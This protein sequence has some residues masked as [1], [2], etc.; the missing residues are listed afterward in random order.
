MNTTKTARLALGSLATAAVLGGG[1]AALSA[2]Q[3]DPMP[4]N[5]TVAMANTSTVQVATADAELT[6][7]LQFAIEEEQMARDLY[8]VLADQY[9]GAAPFVN[10]TRS[11][12]KHY[13]SVSTLL[14]RYGVEDLG[15]DLPVGSFAN[16]DVQKLYDDWLAQ[17][18]TSLEDAYD[19]GI[20]LEKRDIADLEDALASD[21]PA[22]VEQV[23]SMLLNAS[24]HHL[25]AYES[26][27]AGTLGT[28]TGPMGRQGDAQRA[29]SGRGP[30]SGGPGAGGQAGGMGMHS[31][32]GNGHGNGGGMGLH[33][34]SGDCPMDTA[35]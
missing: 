35:S 21:L 27:A 4:T 34:G 19:V 32:G 20:A 29:P 33:D 7:M 16:A 23:F 14:D 25:S 12:Q 8:Q 26:A 9:D 1:W 18:S 11:E 24:Q 15:A 30:G 31:S 5:G 10:I 17:G 28:G 2:A 22:D 3:A 6:Q 13:D